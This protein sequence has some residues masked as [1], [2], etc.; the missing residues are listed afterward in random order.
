MVSDFPMWMPGWH[1]ALA[2][3]L[4]SAGWLALVVLLV[5]A[6][7][8]AA[9]RCEGGRRIVGAVACFYG[10]WLMM[11]MA[12]PAWFVSVG[13]AALPWPWW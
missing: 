12:V 9:W 7:A 11:V 2:Y 5:L 6:G 1:L 3:R 10:V 4:G 8:A 13:L